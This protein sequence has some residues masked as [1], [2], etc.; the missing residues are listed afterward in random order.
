MKVSARLFIDAL[1]YAINQQKVYEV[2]GP[3]DTYAV[4]SANAINISLVK[5]ENSIYYVKVFFDFVSMS[6]ENEGDVEI[7][8]KWGY[9]QG[10]AIEEVKIIKR[11]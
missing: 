1:N 7:I 10:F 11:A 6:H 3:I 5:S 4:F 9:P 8:V 2:L